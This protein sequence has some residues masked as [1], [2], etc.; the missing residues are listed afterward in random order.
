MVGGRMIGVA[1]DSQPIKVSFRSN[2]NRW[3]TE[4]VDGASYRTGIAGKIIRLEISVFSRKSD[5]LIHN[6]KLVLLNPNPGGRAVRARVVHPQ[7]K[8]LM[9]SYPLWRRLTAAIPGFDSPRRHSA[10]G[11]A[12]M[13]CCDKDVEN[14]ELVNRREGKKGESTA[15]HVPSRQCKKGWP[16]KRGLRMRDEPKNSKNVKIE[17]YLRFLVVVLALRCQ[18]M[19]ARWWRSIPTRYMFAAEACFTILLMTYNSAGV[20]IAVTAMIYKVTVI[21]GDENDTDVC[22]EPVVNETFIRKPGEFEWD[23]M[24]RTT[25]IAAGEIGMLFSY[26]VSARICEIFGTRYIVGFSFLINGGVACLQPTFIRLN[27]WL[28]V[29]GSVIP[30]FNILFTRW[31]IGKE[32]M[33]VAALVFSAPKKPWGYCTVENNC[34]ILTDTCFY[35]GKQIVPRAP[36]LKIIM[37]LPLWA[38]IAVSMST[39]WINYTISIQLPLYLTK[40]FHFNI[41]TDGFEITWPNEIGVRCC[42][43]YYNGNFSDMPVALPLDSGVVTIE[44]SSLI[45]RSHDYY[46]HTLLHRQQVRALEPKWRVTL[47]ATVGPAL[48]IIIIPQLKCDKVGVMNLLSITMFL[49]GAYLGGSF[50]N[51]LDIS[52]NYA[53]SVA[54][55]VST[56]SGL[57]Q[58]GG[59]LAAGALTNQ[60][61]T[62]TTWSKV[63]YNSSGISFFPVFLFLVFGSTFQQYWDKLDHNEAD[64]PQRR[65]NKS[66]NTISIK[67]GSKYPQMETVD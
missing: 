37:S 63:F 16:P 23:G 43:N 40:V 36:W 56:L 18:L 67:F 14:Q 59:P 35:V 24:T 1:W 49:N 7:L 48:M 33:I 10:Q 11:P 13:V 22:H 2:K 47:S 34:L 5:I 46:K 26:L 27:V 58:V 12:L 30:G 44:T 21:G 57:I 50:M 15:N 62:L 60:E 38:H 25:V 42:Y 64:I 31:L 17:H 45:Q 3:I 41:E 61:D 53:G 51:Q 19:E 32:R 52:P 9:I 29:C 66:V 65:K 8:D 6:S 54:A 20:P 28:Y 4:T 55:F 39:A